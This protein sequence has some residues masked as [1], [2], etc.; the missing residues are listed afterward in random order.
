FNPDWIVPSHFLGII[1]ECHA[2]WNTSLVLQ[3]DAF[4]F[5]QNPR[6]RYEGTNATRNASKP[7][8]F[9]FGIDSMSRMNFRRTMPL[10]SKFVHQ[11]G[12]YE[13]EGYNS[14]TDK[15]PWKEQLFCDPRKPPCPNDL[16]LLWEHFRSAGYLTAYAE[17]VTSG[18][19]GM[20]S[21]DFN[22]HPFLVV[23][24]KVF[25]TVSKFGY[26]LGRRRS[27][28][29]VFDFAKQLIQRYVLKL[30]MPLFG[31]FWT[32]S[33]TQND[34]RGGRN[35][36]K[37]FVRYLE[38]FQKFGLFKSSIVVLVSDR[39]SRHGPLVDHPSGF[40]EER[41]PMLHIYLPRWYRRI[42]PTKVKALQ[43]NR[44][45]LSSSCDLS[46]GVRQLIEE[47]H[48]GI[49][50]NESTFKCQSILKELPRVRSCDDASIPANSC[51]CKLFLRVPIGD[52]IAKI[53]HVVVH[54][55]N[56]YLKRLN[57]EKKC[58]LM[59]L[60]QVLKAERQLHF[61]RQGEIVPSPSGLETFHLMFTTKPYGTR[62][63]SMV[64]SNK[65]NTFVTTQLKM[66]TRLGPLSN[67]SYCV[68][69]EMAKKFCI[70]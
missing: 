15:T 68:K 70:C 34:F 59:E 2:L 13:M 23:I 64:Q 48:P 55:M 1:V 33:F 47:A 29:Y 30:P 21:V 10:T 35:L 19:L 56:K 31:V 16:T 26:C 67:D 37:L 51:A 27:F 63:C 43:L 58:H 17:D 53:A 36:D 7:S 6:N 62:F 22:L 49:G 61:G 46:L 9:I 52:S 28:S 20:G 3:R 8:V 40:L 39:G 24:E 42:H 41:L 4:S 50:L 18:H 57:V 12:W 11:E 25:K 5:V 44:N 14:V 45:R 66:I 54:R 60:N 65:D 32:S 38:E 69:D